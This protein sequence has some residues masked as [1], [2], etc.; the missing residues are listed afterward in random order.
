MFLEDFKEAYGQEFDKPCLV[1][2][3]SPFTGAI[4]A[5]DVKVHPIKSTKRYKK[6]FRYIF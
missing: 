6:H 1:A 3:N 2:N 5:S 4:N